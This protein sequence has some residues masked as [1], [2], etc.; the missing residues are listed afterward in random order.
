[1]ENDNSRR[2][3]PP[4]RP[5]GARHGAHFVA[6]ITAI[7]LLIPDP[8]AHARE[9][10]GRDLVG[11]SQLPNLELL[12]DSAGDRKLLLLG[13]IS[14]FMLV[15]LIRLCFEFLR[16]QKRQEKSQPQEPMP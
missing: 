4:R 15:I 16:P 5:P 9:A 2:W 7:L 13:V 6:V 8:I 12:G 3:R 10:I 1:M 14:G 11:S